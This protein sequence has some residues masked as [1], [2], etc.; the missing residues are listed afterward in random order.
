[1]PLTTADPAR[2]AAYRLGALTLFGAVAVIL[3]ALAFQYWGGYQPCP[4]CL[5]QR[6]A[7]YAG[8][9]VLFIALVLIGAGYRRLA[10]LLFAAVALGF[11]VNAGLGIYQS[12]MEWK[13]WDAP[14][15]CTAEAT[16]APGTGS[17]SMLERLSRAK[18]VRC[19]EPAFRFLG[20][21]FAGWNVVTSLL[22]LLGATGAAL[23]S[24]RA[25]R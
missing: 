16:S 24:V 22:L 20:L 12:G 10:A 4:L 23:K 18:A 3:A 2:S 5:Q 19:D 14:T 21:S 8:I 13:F 17:G 15:T 11:L 9:P 25:N 6:Y 7:Y 1:M